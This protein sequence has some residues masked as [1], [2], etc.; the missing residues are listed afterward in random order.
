MSQGEALELDQLTN[1]LQ[2]D[3]RTLQRQW[4]EM[5]HDKGYN[6]KESRS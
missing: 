5:R 6:L 2:I 3:R 1:I 4:E